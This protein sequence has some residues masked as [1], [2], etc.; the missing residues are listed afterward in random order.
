MALWSARAVGSPPLYDLRARRRGPSNER[1]FRPSKLRRRAPSNSRLMSLTQP[2]SPPPP[3]HD[4]RSG[5]IGYAAAFGMVLASTAVAELLNRLLQTNRL[6]PVFLAAVL[7][8][9]VT[10]GSGPAYFAAL[11]AFGIYNF[12]LVEPRFTLGEFT[13]EDILLLTVFLA[14]AMLTGR[15]AGR[16]RDQAASA[17]ARARTTQALFEASREF[18]GLNEEEF[19]R[20]GL[21][22]HVNEVAGAP[23][24]L[25]RDGAWRTSPEG[26][27]VPSAVREAL[28]GA[29]AAGSIA[30]WRVRPLMVDQ[31][32]LGNLAWRETGARTRGEDPLVDVLVDVGAAAIIR[33]RLGAAEAEVRAM[34]E[35][36]RLRNAL[37]SSISHDLRTPLASI[38]ASVSSL[39]EFGD[40]F[41]PAVTEDLL[42]TIQEEA[43]R[44]NQFVAN[45]L[46]MTRLEGGGLGVTAVRTDVREVAGR[47]VDRLRR[48]A[49]RRSLIIAQDRL[50]VRADPI[51]LEQALGNVVENAIRFT[52]DGSTIELDWRRDGERVVLEIADD[53]P[54]V[55]PEDLCRIFEKFYRSPALSANLQGTGL[56]LS[57]VRGLMESMDGGAEARA[58]EG[59]GLIVSL[60]LPAGD[61]T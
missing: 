13:A 20:S 48:R 15:L 10:F 43:E 52:P 33:A 31:P 21:L 25:W 34:A 49:G 58:R 57:I 51:L 5:R 54:G 24:A 38:L 18:S 37:L 53:G 28:A 26:A 8:T 36:E 30:G 47:V 32:E 50:D 11:L 29:T 42:S 23:A 27:A 44:L 46:H 7:I 1:P 6:S 22:K 19:I 56:G 12:Y 55:P 61:E 3:R 14:V 59:G 17:Q 4:A 39:R 41:E 45:L 2:K 16:V 9:A 35:T 60:H 40:R